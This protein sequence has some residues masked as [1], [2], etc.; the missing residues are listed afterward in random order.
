[1]ITLD[2]VKLYSVNVEYWWE[3]NPLFFVLSSGAGTG[4]TED[5]HT[6]RLGSSE[7][8]VNDFQTFIHM[9]V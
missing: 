7:E 2:K 1:M 4:V 5:V 8:G 3:K 6:L 9:C